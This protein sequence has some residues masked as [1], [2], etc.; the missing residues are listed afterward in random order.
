[1]KKIVLTMLLLCTAVVGF[2]QQKKTTQNFGNGFLKVTPVARNAVRIQYYE[3]ELNDAGLPDW[4]YEGRATAVDNCGLNVDINSQQ[5]LLTIKNASGTPVF[6]AT[7]HS[8]Q[9]T[10][11][12][13]AFA[14]PKDEYLFGLGQ[15]Q[16][17][18][19]NIRGLSRRLT[20]VNTQISV[21]MML[22]NK[23]YGILWNNYGLVDFNPA[24]NSIVLQANSYTASKKDIVDVTST[25]G[26][27]KEV[28]ERNIFE[29]TLNI[30]EGGQY[31]LLLDVGQKMARRHNL[32]I[33]G[34]PVIEMQNLWLPPTA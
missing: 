21:P 10:Q 20:Q 29:G 31:S 27:K 8:M 6:T 3:K 23:G 32:V 1:M 12:Q 15:F 30:A 16:D 25:E 17:G 9:G 26:G 4:L 24:D 5:Q 34:A 7:K 2:A 19:S 13:L 28:R 11:A 18:Y 33:D 22:S 14:S